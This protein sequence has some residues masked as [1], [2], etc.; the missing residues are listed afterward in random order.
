MNVFGCIMFVCWL[1]CCI[2][3]GFCAIPQGLWTQYVVLNSLHV[4]RCACMTSRACLFVCAVQRSICHLSG[5]KG[6]PTFSC[7]AALCSA[8]VGV[9]RNTVH[10]P[11]TSAS[12]EYCNIDFVL[13]CTQLHV[14]YLN[15]VIV[16][17]SRLFRLFSCC[18]CLVLEYRT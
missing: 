3:V 2:C 13:Q 5:V 8:W 17:S 7:A 6:W 18:H 12:H 16:F 15:T 1:I 14:A 11:C 9:Q 4:P 10:D